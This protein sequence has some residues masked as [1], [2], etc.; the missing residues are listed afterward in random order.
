MFDQFPPIV[1][2]PFYKRWIFWIVLSYIIFITIYTL[3]SMQ[4]GGEN[5]F[6]NSNEL[7]DFLAGIFAPLAFLFLYLGYIQQ[8]KELQQN[9]QALSLQA[10]EL[11]NLVNNQKKE[12]EARDFSVQPFLFLKQNFIK[13]DNQESQD[14][15]GNVNY[16]NIIQISFELFFQG[17]DAKYIELI[18]PISKEQL[19][20]KYE[21]KADSGYQTKFYL[22]ENYWDE[23]LKNNSVEFC[24]IVYYFG[25]YGKQYN[26]IIVIK[27]FDF[28]FIHETAEIAIRLNGTVWK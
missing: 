11:T 22:S 12:I 9:T 4:A 3:Y 5:R 14:R 18:D 20:S 23:L 24:L 17:G 2:K 27:I 8:S 6:L 13:L 7:G 10:H 19:D 28:D 21:I 25:K 1:N 15:Y 26:N 16:K